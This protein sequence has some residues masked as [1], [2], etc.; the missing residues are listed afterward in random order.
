TQN[1]VFALRKDSKDWDRLEKE[2]FNLVDFGTKEFESALK[3][4]DK[5]I[6]S[7]IDGYLVEY[8]GKNTLD[9]K[10][11]VFLQHGITQNNLS[12]WLNN[13]QIDCFITATQKEYE[14]IAN[15]FNHYKFSN[16]EVVLT[17]FAR[18]DSLLEKNKTNTKQILIMPTWRKNLVETVSRSA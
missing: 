8:F 16:K 3:S 5:I 11:F 1:I 15:D 12:N 7:H 2:G 10:Q 14:S 13:K 6:S 17:G 4:C 18:H 9:N